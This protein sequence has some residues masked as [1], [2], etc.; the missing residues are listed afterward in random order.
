MSEG[1]V[2]KIC[3][4]ECELAYHL[5]LLKLDSDIEQL[6]E[7][8]LAPVFTSH[9]FSRRCRDPSVSK[10]TGVVSQYG[11]LAGIIKSNGLDSMALEDKRTWEKDP[12]LFFNVSSPS[13][14]FISVVFHY[15]TFICDNGGSPCEAAFL[16]S[17]PD[18]K[19]RVLCAPTNLRTIQGTYSRF[20]IKVEALQ[21]DQADLNTRRM[22]DLMAVG[23]DNGPLP[24]YMHTVQRILREMRVEQQSLGTGF[25][26]AE[27]KGRILDSGLTPG[28]LEPLKQRLDT[29]ES[30]MPPQQAF[31]RTGKN[32]KAKRWGSA[33]TPQ[34]SQ[35]TIVDLSCPCIS[36]DTACSLFNICFGIFLEQTTH[37]GRIVALDEAHKYMDNSVEA[38]SFT[39]T[40]L[41]TVRLQ[42]H[43]GIR[44]V[45]STQEPTISTALLGLC[46]VTIVHRFS[47][48]EWLHTLKKHIAG[49]SIGNILKLAVQFP[50]YRSGLPHS[51]VAV[52]VY[53]QNS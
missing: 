5:S 1:S 2:C 15:D 33:W 19:V 35:L 46:S 30:F 28:Q 51:I 4:N 13:S 50:A 27:F 11:L 40:L 24:L 49:V 31:S 37:V 32:I 3:P 48:P 26:Y 39:E 6:E 41:S 25:D 29:L 20:N 44:I 34:P 36:S 16:A 23:Q 22:L 53:R 43:L 10:P 18:I 52:D 14:T 17:N 47:S 38:R 9:V 7:A 21:I 12:R 8:S 45:I 42:R